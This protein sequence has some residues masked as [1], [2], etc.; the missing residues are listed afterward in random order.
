MLAMSPES[1]Y[2]ERM[3][4]MVS[5]RNEILAANSRNLSSS[6]LPSA[7]FSANFTSSPSISSSTTFLAPHYATWRY[8]GKDNYIES[9]YAF[10]TLSPLQAAY[11]L[12]HEGIPNQR[13]RPFKFLSNSVV[14]HKYNQ[15]L[16]YVYHPFSFPSF[17][18]SYLF[19]P[20]FSL[21]FSSPSISTIILF[22]SP[23]FRRIQLL[24]YDHEVIV[25]I[26]NQKKLETGF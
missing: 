26:K 17:S 8:N 14:P 3:Y 11:Q 7:S 18:S 19:S 15:Y 23:L 16:V 21:F 1:T 25:H 12:W 6:S 5:M 10:P 20:I 13:L 2:E 4:M 9:D 22:Y 24:L